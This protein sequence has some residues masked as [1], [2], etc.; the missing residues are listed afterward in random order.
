MTS[1][2][3]YKNVL[4]KIGQLRIYRK[5]VAEYNKISCCFVSMW[6]IKNID[7]IEKNLLA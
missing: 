7:V 6:I 4:I 5:N 3:L 1:I 2:L